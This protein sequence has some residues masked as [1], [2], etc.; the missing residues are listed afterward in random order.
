MLKYLKDKFQLMTVQE[1]ENVLDPYC[2]MINDYE[3]ELVKL[4]RT[5]NVE[6]DRRDRAETE[7]EKFRAERAAEFKDASV[8]RER[9]NRVAEA[10]P[11][12]E[13]VLRRLTS[14][15]YAIG[16]S[17]PYDNEDLSDTLTAA[18][19]VYETYNEVLALIRK[20]EDSQFG[21]ASYFDFSFDMDASEPIDS[22]HKSVRLVMEA[23]AVNVLV[24]KNL[25]RD[26][27]EISYVASRLAEDMS[28]K[29]KPE[30]FHRARYLLRSGA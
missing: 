16:N 2:K 7:N 19:R 12:L 4:R 11:L 3:D 10:A 6:R 15:L 30:I 23:M 1:H 8:A 18:A 27:A 5:L 28:R 14:L 25:L 17:R 13:P 29:M 20:Y 21:S 9:L 22:F 24:D 26:E